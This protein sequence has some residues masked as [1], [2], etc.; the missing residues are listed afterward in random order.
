MLNP[1]AK[2]NLDPKIQKGISHLASGVRTKGKPQISA[3]R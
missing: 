1:T 2:P 3:Q